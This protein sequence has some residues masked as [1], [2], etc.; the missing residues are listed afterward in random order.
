MDAFA[1]YVAYGF[2]LCAAWGG[3]LAILAGLCQARAGRLN[4]A[5]P[6]AEGEG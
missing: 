5:G 6:D 2:A 4:G 3:G 1:L